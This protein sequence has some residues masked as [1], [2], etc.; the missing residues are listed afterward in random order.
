MTQLTK[1]YIVSN[2]PKWSN[3]LLKM[4][5]KLLSL[6]PV[7][8]SLNISNV[9]TKKQRHGQKIVP[10]IL[11]L[12]RMG[13]AK[14]DPLNSFSAVTSTNIG[15]SPQ[16]ILSFTFNPFATLVLNFKVIPSANPKLFQLN[17]DH[18]SKK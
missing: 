13:G 17:Q 2:V 3:L 14:K 12:F 4:G 11:T 1:L 15:L 9:V 18:P 10:D 5:Q 16:N 8:Y 6:A 7:L